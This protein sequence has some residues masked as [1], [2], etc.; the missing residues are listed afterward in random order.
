MADK[1]LTTT[2]AAGILGVSRRH[3]TTLVKSGRL[4]ARESVR[5]Y[6]V[7]E[8]DVRQFKPAPRGR[9]PKQ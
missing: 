8:S 5:G 4:P 1:L 6:L 7:R 9:P 3:V 2:Q